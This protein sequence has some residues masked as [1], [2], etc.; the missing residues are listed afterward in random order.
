MPVVTVEIADEC[1][2]SVMF[3]PLQ[4]KLRGRWDSQNVSYK[5]AHQALAR[6]P[7][8]IPGIQIIVDTN[9][10]TRGYFDPLSKP[11]HAGTID[12]LKQA[13]EEISGITP[14]CNPWPAVK[15][16]N[17][18]DSDIKTWL[19]WMRRLVDNGQAILIGDPASLPSMEEIE[20]LKGDVFVGQFNTL[21][22]RRF[23]KDEGKEEPAKTSSKAGA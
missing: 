9:R 18:S 2:R 22:T 12:L 5:R 13:K 23:K 10:K 15:F 21:A 3:H 6:L 7:N 19:Y 20:S 4:Q 11:E 16:D 1:N 14:G 8:V 17:S